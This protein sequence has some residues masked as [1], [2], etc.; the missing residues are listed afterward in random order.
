VSNPPSHLTASELWLALQ[1]TPRPHRVV[2][3]PR[4][5]P[6]GTPVGQVAMWPLSQEE[7]CMATAAA[8]KYVRRLLP[9]TKK[10]ALG[11]EN[12]YGNAVATEMMFLACRDMRDITRPAFP[13]AQAIREVLTVDETAVLFEHYLSVQL[14]VGPIVSQMS[15]KQYEAWIARLVEGQNAFPFDLMSS[16]VQKALLRRMASQLRSLQTATFSAGSPPDDG[17]ARSDE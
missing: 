12:L 16:A 14:E 6:D 8:E 9:E 10:D 1:P 11:Y 15:T 17:T 2:D 3:F 13:S 7:H 5:T 4:K